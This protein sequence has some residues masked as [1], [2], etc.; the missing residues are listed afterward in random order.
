[1]YKHNYIENKNQ[2]F[3]EEN[4]EPILHCFNNNI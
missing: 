2:Y 3:E 1:M 4:N